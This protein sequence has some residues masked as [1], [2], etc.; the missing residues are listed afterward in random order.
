MEV[1]LSALLYLCVS[2]TACENKVY[3]CFEDLKIEHL[4]IQVSRE[5]QSDVFRHCFD[6]YIVE[7]ENED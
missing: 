5:L 4:D 1:V 7:E 6:N 3:Q 2:E